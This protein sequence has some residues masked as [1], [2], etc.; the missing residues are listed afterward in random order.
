M[1]DRVSYALPLGP[2]G[3]LAHRL[4]VKRDIERIFDFRAEKMRELFPG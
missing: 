3:T 4:W 2:C 1:R